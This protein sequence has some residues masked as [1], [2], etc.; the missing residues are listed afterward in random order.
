[1]RILRKVTFDVKQLEPDNKVH[2]NSY[3]A[4]YKIKSGE[5]SAILSGKVFDENAKPNFDH[6][7]PLEDFFKVTIE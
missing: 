6:V 3:E 7:K 5:F 2:V 4:I 1:M